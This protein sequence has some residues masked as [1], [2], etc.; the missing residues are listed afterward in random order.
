MKQ[1]SRHGI[2]STQ[3]LTCFCHSLHTNAFARVYC[4]HFT[5]RANAF[6][7]AYA[8]VSHTERNVFAYIT[9]Y[10]LHQMGTVHVYTFTYT[11]K[12]HIHYC[13]Y[14]LWIE[15]PVLVLEMPEMYVSCG[16][17]MY[18][19]MFVIIHYPTCI[20]LCYSYIFNVNMCCTYFV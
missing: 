9:P 3:V 11:L 4:T 10:T 12:L 6:W 5:Q 1:Q 20:F 15:P 7:F 18:M 13:F 8:H 17:Y 14:Q 19:L 2:I 16:L